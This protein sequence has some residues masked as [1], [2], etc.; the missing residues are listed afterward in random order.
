[1][2]FSP[3]SIPVIAPVT[4]SAGGVTGGLEG[5]AGYILKKESLVSELQRPVASA[6]Q[7]LPPASSETATIRK[8]PEDNE[9]MGQHASPRRLHTCLASQFMWE[10]AGSFKPIQPRIGP[11]G[12]LAST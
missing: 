5:F 7:R 12:E 8:G 6:T 11:W 3:F 1:M 2:T 10:S 4:P 9:R